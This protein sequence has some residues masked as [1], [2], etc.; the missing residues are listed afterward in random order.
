[1]HIITK[2]AFNGFNDYVTETNS[3]IKYCRIET[4]TSC[5]QYIYFVS[6]TSLTNIVEIINTVLLTTEY[7]NRHILNSDSITYL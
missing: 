3:S 7:V 1:M 2:F 5:L 6:N 4:D